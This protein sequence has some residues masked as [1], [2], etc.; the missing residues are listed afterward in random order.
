MA[1]ARFLA[2]KAGLAGKNEWEQG[3]A[4]AAV[5]HISDVFVSKLI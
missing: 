3:Q 1:I 5:D 4:D 2:K